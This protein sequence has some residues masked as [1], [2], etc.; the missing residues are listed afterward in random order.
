MRKSLGH[1]EGTMG[2]KVGVELLPV[3]PRWN[4]LSQGPWRTTK[5]GCKVVRT[6]ARFSELRKVGLGSEERAA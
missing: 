5:A 4:E 3:R 1:L 2:G 6:A